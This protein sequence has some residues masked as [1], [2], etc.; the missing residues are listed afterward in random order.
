MRD[1]RKIV[2]VRF[3]RYSDSPLKK[4]DHRGFRGFPVATISPAAS[5]RQ[6]ASSVCHHP[7]R[8][9]SCR[10]AARRNNSLHWRG[11]CL[12][13]RFR[14]RYRHQ[15]GEPA[16]RQRQ[17]AH[18]F[19]CHLCR[20]RARQLA[21]R[22]DHASQWRARCF[23][24]HARRLRRHELGQ[25]AGRQWRVVYAVSDLWYRSFTSEFARLGCDSFRGCAG[26]FSDWS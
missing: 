24:D 3:K 11:G 9:R 18:T 23:L 8:R 13:D 2:C 15:L 4:K 21:P 22:C 17:L 6:L 26:R 10:L 5:L 25:P 12:L 14:R 7:V 1:F 16:D 20:R 19:P